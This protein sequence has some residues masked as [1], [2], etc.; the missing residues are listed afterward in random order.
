MLPCWA[1]IQTCRPTLFPSHHQTPDCLTSVP[2]MI[3]NFPLYII[4]S[5]FIS[6]WE[7]KCL[8]VKSCNFA[9]TSIE[10]AFFINPPDRLTSY[11]WMFAWDWPQDLVLL[12]PTNDSVVLVSCYFSHW[13]PV[14]AP[15]DGNSSQEDQSARRNSKKRWVYFNLELLTTKTLQ[16]QID[17]FFQLTKE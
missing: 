12:L 2:G 14:T 15:I 7:E 4:T 8:V 3:L 16:C 11:S 10:V 5:E 1:S 13:D 17:S 9:S 6:E